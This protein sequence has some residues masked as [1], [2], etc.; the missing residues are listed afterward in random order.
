MPLL[1]REA[2]KKMKQTVKTSS[3]AK[4]SVEKSTG[5]NR[6]KNGS[7]VCWMQ[8]MMWFAGAVKGKKNVEV[9]ICLQLAER[10]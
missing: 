6:D 3:T 2:V 8:S 4:D 9:T 1:L 7:C 5:A 10:E